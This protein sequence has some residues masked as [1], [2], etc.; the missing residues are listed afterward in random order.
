MLT[1]LTVIGIDPRRHHMITRK[2]LGLLAGLT[3]V[4][5]AVAAIIGQNRHG[6]IDIIGRIVW[7]SFVAC[8]LFLLVG[9]IATIARRGQR[10][11]RSQETRHR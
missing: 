7:W 10:R 11:V 5:F 2:S 1:R 3:L 9:S 8:A 6:T 4:L